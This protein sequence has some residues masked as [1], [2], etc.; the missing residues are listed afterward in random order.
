MLRPTQ[1]LR[2]HLDETSTLQPCLITDAKALYDSYHKESLAGASS[3][4]KRT[5]LE[6]RVAKEQ[7]TSLG[8]MLR[9]VS[10][11]RQYADG[12]TKM[13][14]RALLAER[15]RYH[16]M[17]LMWDPEYTSAKKKTAAER[18]KPA[19]LSLQSRRRKRR[20]HKQPHQHF[21]HHFNTRHLNIHNIP[22]CL[23]SAI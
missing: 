22:T 10:S 20:N 18:V 11:E 21:H 14:T 5:G 2:D 17:K 13:S 12:L 4:D 7:L 15:I 6:I 19:E 23:K 1:N 9:W 16:K 8:G 3:V